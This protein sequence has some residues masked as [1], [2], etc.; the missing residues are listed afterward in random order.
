MERGYLPPEALRHIDTG[1]HD[2]GHDLA[3]QAV[4]M[5]RAVS[6]TAT[7]SPWARHIQ[8]RALIRLR[9]F[10]AAVAIFD[11]LMIELAADGL[12]P[13]VAGLVYC[14]AIEGCQEVRDPRRAEEDRGPD[15]VVSRLS[16]M[17]PF[18]GQ[19]MV[20]RA[21]ILT[22]F[23]APGRRPPPR[24]TMRSARWGAVRGRCRLVRA[25]RTAP[26]YRRLRSGRE[27]VPPDQPARP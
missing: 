20:Y 18:G 17:S 22:L 12:S 1:S 23:T 9:R 19:C 6:S 13:V 15:P 16:P 21:Q 10:A 14:S 2:Q 11:E 24:S 3:A 4:G 26:T 5:G 25:G 27:G 7:W 8:A